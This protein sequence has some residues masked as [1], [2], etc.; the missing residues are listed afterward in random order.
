[1]AQEGK[2]IEVAAIK[3]VQNIGDLYVAVVNA[4]DLL[5][6][7][8]VDRIRMRMFKVPKYAGYQRALSETRV[9]SIRDY[10]STPRSTFPNS[11]ICSL[12]SQFIEAWDDV[13]PERGL[14]RIRILRDAGAV[15]IIDG[16]H[17]TAA[18]DQASADFEVVVTFFVDLD[19]PRSAEIFSKI[20][21][22]QKA[23]NP[24]IA[25]QLFGYSEDR[26]PQR[27]AHEISEIM[28]TTEGS[29]FYRRLRMLGTKDSWSLGTLSQA[30]FAKQLMRL[31]TRK[32]EEDQ[33]ALLRRDQ[34][35]DYPGYPMRSWFA[36][37][38]DE[39]ILQTTWKY[40]YRVA[41][42]WPEQWADSTGHSILTKTTGYTA[43]VEVMRSWLRGERRD[44]VMQ[45]EGVQDAFA[46]IKDKYET[47]EYR[48]VRDNY[49][50]GNQGVQLLRNRLLEDLRIEY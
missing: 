48:F 44:E 8:E 15:K 47:D 6:I 29:P 37:G 19:V 22:T 41:E 14:S 49:P 39:E 25:F 33:N 21:S 32:P 43:L 1:M 27:T 34:L 16:Q 7:A 9:K 30:T 23:V 3:A 5:A 2:T 20:N 45:D 18:L 17:R 35:K 40:F 42:T 10:L 24:S 31:Y 38:L 11:I 12:D 50:A 13:D 28:N 36:E 46:A 4:A 26:S